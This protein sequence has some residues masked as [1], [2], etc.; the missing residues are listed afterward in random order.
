M[1]TLVVSLGEQSVLLLLT[2]HHGREF[3]KM[4]LTPHSRRTLQMK[5]NTTLT[6]QLN[7]FDQLTLTQIELSRTKEE[8]SKANLLVDKILYSLSHIIRQPLSSAMGLINLVKYDGMNSFQSASQFCNLMNRSLKKMDE[9]FHDLQVYCQ[10]T[11]QVSLIEKIEV[12]KLIRDQYRMLE[13][14]YDCPSISLSIDVVETLDFYGD[15]NLVSFAIRNVLS[16]AIK[17]QDENKEQKCINI[18]GHIDPE[19]CWIEIQDNGIGISETDLLQLSKIFFTDDAPRVGVGLGL[20]LV[21]ECVVK[22]GG[23]L[24][25][26]SRLNEGTRVRVRLPNHY[27]RLNNGHQNTRQV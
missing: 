6:K 21:N 22:S 24:I 5:H 4:K 20:A 25:I 18:V 2:F 10:T 17:F 1:I 15:F 12:V 9:G 23:Q 16:N 14:E 11:R 27:C 7:A 3:I 19:Y 26:N 8:L 13:N